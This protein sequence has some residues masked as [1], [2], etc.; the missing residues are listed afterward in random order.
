MFLLG[1]MAC[2]EFPTVL[3]TEEPANNCVVNT[4]DLVP[5]ENDELVETGV[6]REVVV[7]ARGRV[8]SDVSFEVDPSTDQPAPTSIERVVY[9][10]LDNVVQTDSFSESFGWPEELIGTRYLATEVEGRT[11]L[12]WSATYG[13]LTVE[14][15]VL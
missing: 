1:V 14:T 5:D 10:E 3:R 7:D 12:A 6:T 2:T 8:V 4:V 11:V 9:D 15:D 13:T